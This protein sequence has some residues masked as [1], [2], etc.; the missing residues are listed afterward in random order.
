MVDATTNEADEDFFKDAF[1]NLPEDPRVQDVEVTSFY[2]WEMLMRFHV[3]PETHVMCSDFMV[4][5]R[6]SF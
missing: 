4:T 5:I 1:Y 6:K 2:G 3:I